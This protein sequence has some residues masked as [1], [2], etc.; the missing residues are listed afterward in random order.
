MGSMFDTHSD[1]SPERDHGGHE[2]CMIE[3]T[4]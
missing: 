4:W 1:D 3:E 2:G